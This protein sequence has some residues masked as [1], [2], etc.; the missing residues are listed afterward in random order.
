MLLPLS[1]PLSPRFSNGSQA[2]K[3][4][5][6]EAFPGSGKLLAQDDEVRRLKEELRITRMEFTPVELQI[7]SDSNGAV[8]Y[9]S[10]TK[11]SSA[12]ALRLWRGS[13]AHCVGSFKVSW[14]SEISIK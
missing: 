6:G 3:R 11:F 5:Q 12:S 1:G 4:D 9:G 14:S 7:N 10:A 8:I 13:E 2:F